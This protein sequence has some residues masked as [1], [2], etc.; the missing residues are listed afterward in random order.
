VAGGGTAEAFD[1]DDFHL[2]GFVDGRL[3]Q[4][5]DEPSCIKGGLGKLRYGGGDFEA[6][7]GGIVLVPW[8]QITPALTGVLDLR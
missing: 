7:A 2:D 3:I 4:P 8:V 1:L 6:N 5:G